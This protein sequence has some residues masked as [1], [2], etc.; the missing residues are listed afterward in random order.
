MSII[1]MHITYCGHESAAK[2]NHVTD[3]AARVGTI[4]FPTFR[5]IL[6][7]SHIFRVSV[8]GPNSF[9]IFMLRNNC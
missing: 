5:D 3:M 1:Q 9:H 7:L 8:V 4:F 2:Y 6:I